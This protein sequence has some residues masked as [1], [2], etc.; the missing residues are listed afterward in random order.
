MPVDPQVAGGEGGQ[1]S[2]EAAVLLGCDTNHFSPTCS[3]ETDESQDLL[4]GCEG[5]FPE[6]DLS[7]APGTEGGCYKGVLVDACQPDGTCPPGKR[8]EAHRGIPREGAPEADYD[9]CVPIDWAAEQE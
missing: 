2:S 5:K 1:A 9:I 3:P 4:W 8:C 7:P 6:V